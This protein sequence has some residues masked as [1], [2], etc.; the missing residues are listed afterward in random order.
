MTHNRLHISGGHLIDPANNINKLSDLFIADGKVVSIGQAPD[1]FQPDQRIDASGLTV[2]PGLIDLCARTG[3]PGSLSKAS[4]A[5]ESQAAVSAGV[6][7]MV[8]PPDTDPVIDSTAVAELIH[9]RSLKV[10]KARIL[11]IGA[12]TQELDGE[13]LASMHGLKELGC[14]AFS[15]ADKPIISSEVLR[16]AMEYAVSCDVPVFLRPQDYWLGK[17]C[18]HEGAISTRLGLPGIPSSAETIALSRDLLL[19]EQTGVR[20]H[21]CRLS[22]AA[23]V[24]MIA[25]AQQRGQAVSADVSM[26][27]LHLTEMDVDF[28]QANTH[29][30]P[31]LRT[32]RDRQALRQGVANGVISSI[33]SDHNPL[34]LDTKTAP[35]SDTFAGASAIETLL[36]LCMKLAS[37]DTVDVLRALAAVTCN[38]ARILGVDLGHLSAG[39]TADI[40][41]FDA[42]VDRILSLADLQSMGKNSPYLDWSL[43][44][45]VSHTLV[46]GQIVYQAKE[47]QQQ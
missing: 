22:T 6:T 40:C 15:N 33:C 42:N 24:D 37:G 36:P 39:A 32:Q 12:L 41:I 47:E 29:L 3:E 27:N 14:L 31:P 2:I 46:G 19:A 25:E 11:T 35:F 16:R 4:I 17:G 43:S 21:F 5:S 28:L 45:R 38:P 44:T 8:C 13:R 30:R 20:V 9:S 1:G 26:Q 18:M 34:D 23:A 7:T 10:G